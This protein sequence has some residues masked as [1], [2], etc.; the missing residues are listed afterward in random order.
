M[1][2]PINVNVPYTISQQPFPVKCQTV[3]F[4]CW[5]TFYLTRIIDDYI[6][7]QFYLAN[8]HIIVDIEIC[9]TV[10]NDFVFTF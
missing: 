5:A 1:R 4:Y 9:V 7:I 6:T 3:P 10:N 2:L 8:V